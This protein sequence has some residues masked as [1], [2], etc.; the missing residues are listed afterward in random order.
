MTALFLFT[1]LIWLLAAVAGR[2]AWRRGEGVF[3]QGARAGWRDLQTLAPRVLLGVL[4][5]GFLARLAPT[6]LIEP[7]L[8]AGSGLRGL[9]LA[10][11]L[12][13]LVPGGPVLAYTLA[14][15]AL[16]AG[17][18]EAQVISFV[19]AWLLYSAHRSLVW[20]APLL[21]GGFLRRRVALSLPVP[22]LVGLGATALF[23]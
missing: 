2:V 3:A 16:G 8:G 15:A 13:A 5:A 1:A 10:S 20:E 22:L 7:A 12:G 19:T 21:G 6:E 18:G 17:A 11:V 4:A 23:G 9:V 14:G